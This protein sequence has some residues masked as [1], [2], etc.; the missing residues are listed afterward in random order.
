M[1]R[2]CNYKQSRPRPS[3]PPQPENANYVSKIEQKDTPAAA[4][5]TCIVY[6]TR[7]SVI[8]ERSLKI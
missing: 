3:P 5:I 1:V 7:K 4:C 2:K 6:R 8:A